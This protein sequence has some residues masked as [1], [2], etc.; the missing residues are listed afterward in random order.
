TRSLQGSDK[1][2]KALAKVQSDNQPLDSNYINNKL[3]NLRSL[4]TKVEDNN[5]L[6]DDKKQALKQEIDKT[7]QSIDRQR[8]II[9]DQ[10]NGA[11]NKKQATE[12]ILNSVFSKNEV[13]DI[14]K[15]IKTNGRSNEDIANQIAKQI[16]GLALTSSDDILKSMLDQSKDKESLIKQLLT[17]R[18][19][20]DEA[21]RIAKK[22]LSQNLS[23]SQIVEQLKRHFNSQGTATADDILN[24]VIN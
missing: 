12:D 10:L 6:S 15:R 24:G 4:D 8:N 13:E 23:N 18:L 7:K 22:L 3:M 14:M 1:I 17:T 19:G 2:E 9:I 11:S 20:N 16:D 21:D 5:T